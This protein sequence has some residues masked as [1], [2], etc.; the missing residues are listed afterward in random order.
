MSA[1][2][3]R[4]GSA[5][6]ATRVRTLLATPLLAL[7]LG[8]LTPLPMLAAATVGPAAPAAAI[9]A[10]LSPR[11]RSTARVGRPKRRADASARRAARPASFGGGPS[12]STRKVGSR[13]VPAEIRA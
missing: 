2:R 4:G 10:R 12:M 11:S 1:E 7:V 13:R 9:R 8:A 6:P 5:A 3:V